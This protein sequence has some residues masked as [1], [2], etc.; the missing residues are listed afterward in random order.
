[1]IRAGAV[2]RHTELLNPTAASVV[3]N[4]KKGAARFGKQ[5][6]EIAAGA[7]ASVSVKLNKK[8]K[9]L[10]RRNGALAVTVRLTPTGGSPITGSVL[11][12]S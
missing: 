1:M 7:T 8:A 12:T 5:R 9:R 6:Y 11:L 2:R 4:A 3:T 10:L